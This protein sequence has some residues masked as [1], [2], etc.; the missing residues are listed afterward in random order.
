LG[1]EVPDRQVTR[2]AAYTLCVEDGRLLLCRIAPGPWS[3][4]GS[5]TLPGGGVDFGE[6]PSVAALRELEEEAGLVG[7]L[8]GLADVFSWSATWRHPHDGAFEE[9]H[10]I[11]IVY[12]ARVIGGELRDEP[13]GST[14]RAAWFGSAEL[15][16]L[17]LVPLAREGARLALGLDLP[18]P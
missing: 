1:A 2:V 5:W 9:F 11:Q 8:D 6:A 12:R 15:V 3:A 10:A 17:S 16:D 13:D 14:D 18:E 7:E 4:V